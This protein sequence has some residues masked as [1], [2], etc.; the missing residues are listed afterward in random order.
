MYGGTLSVDSLEM[1]EEV[2]LWIIGVKNV[3]DA[4]KCTTSFLISSI[5]AGTFSV[6]PKEHME[7]HCLGQGTFNI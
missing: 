7:N 6:E 4:H 1:V 2:E 3:P 5:L